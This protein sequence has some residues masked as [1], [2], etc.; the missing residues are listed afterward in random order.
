[1]TAEG[2]GVQAILD[3]KAKGYQALVKA[4]ETASQAA[5]LLL[6]EKLQEIAGIQAQAI[7]D[8]PIEKIIVWDGGGKEGGL[9]G[10]GG[11]LMG[12]LPP[13]H[14]LAKQVGLELPDFLGKVQPEEKKEETP[15]IK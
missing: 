2:A 6:I 3:G 14:E 1:M 11:R 10:L 8:L 9:N 13:M 7:Q 15:A 5:S 4:C 12:A